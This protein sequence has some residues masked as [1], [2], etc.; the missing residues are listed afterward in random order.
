[1][2]KRSGIWLVFGCLLLAGG[3]SGVYYAWQEGHI[4]ASVLPPHPRAPLPQ[5]FL[6]TLQASR[7]AAQALRPACVRLNLYTSREIDRMGRPGLSH[8]RMPGWDVIVIAQVPGES[9]QRVGTLTQAL[10]AL[11]KA[12]LYAVS[13]D[14]TDDGAGNKL[15]AK[16]YTLTFAGWDSMLD[17]QCF[18]IGKTQVTE[19]AEFSRIMP[20]KDGKRIYEIK[21]KYSPQQLPAWID[22][23]AIQTLVSPEQLK[24]LRE[25]ATATFRLL[26]TG[27]GW[28]VE[29]AE[30]EPP[31]LTRDVVMA[32]IG[33]YRGGNMPNACVRLPAKNAPPG[34]DVALAPYS[35][36]MFDAEGQNEVDQ[37]FM[38]QLMWQSRFAQL[39]KAGIFT[40]EKV[41]A[42][43]K[44]NVPAGTRYALAPAYQ[45]L[46][47]M[48]DARC[49]KMGDV[50]M[51][52]ISVEV[53]PRREGSEA[54]TS[55][56]TAKLVL[57]L[58]KEAW[59]NKANLA[60]PDVEAV[61]DAGGVPVMARLMWS[62]RDK[63][64]EWRIVGLQAPQAELAPPRMRRNALTP[65]LASIPTSA[66][67]APS[68]TAVAAAPGDVVWQSGGG[69]TGGR[70]TNA[71]LTATYCCAG[72]S[73][74]T[75]SSQGV[76][77]GKVYAEFT[78]TARP[79]SLQGDTYT[80]IGAIPAPAGRSPAY[81]ASNTPTMA[82]QRGSDI[83]HTDIVG[84][85]IDMDAGKLYFSRNGAWLNGQPGSGGGIALTR[86]QTY[87]IAAVLS[88]SSS[89][90]GTDSWTANF[91][92]TKFRYALPRGF[93]SLDGRQRG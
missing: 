73:S 15:P 32:L 28:D 91:G 16:K 75:L 90:P 92:R 21:A 22:D 84:V 59:I 1:M 62:E 11:A 80:N 65:A 72:A 77:S 7:T 47:D 43:P 25:P 52:F 51:E 12:G 93:K 31:E 83:A 55:N 56:A 4:P 19:V 78:F 29:K 48:D 70:V 37:R 86:G 66:A 67:I 58:D 89:S 81:V 44:L 54:K 6:T 74:T 87:H 82:F 9:G 18:K 45:P 40:E 79:R 88:A 68:A 2:T 50:K 13:D 5:N 46:L 63:D 24:K 60:L 8:M 34:F 27:E 38:A 42:N 3:L 26:R 17:D 69:G 35:A 41:A 85:A 30:N 64:K 20:D 14:E 76:A 53:Q 33:K 39:V 23:P 10:T 49:L 61:K 36:T 57:R 71:G